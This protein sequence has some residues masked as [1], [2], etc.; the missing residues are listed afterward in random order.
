MYRKM[1]AV[2]VEHLSPVPWPDLT[3]VQR[4]PFG[5][6]EMTPAR[7]DLDLQERVTM[8]DPWKQHMLPHHH[9]L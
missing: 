2:G 1:S 5:W 3:D 8:Q 4:P 7:A 6:W 9:H